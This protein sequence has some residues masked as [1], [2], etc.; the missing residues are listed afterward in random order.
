[1]LTM[2]RIPKQHRVEGHLPC[3]GRKVRENGGYGSRG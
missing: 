1:M 3:I 2:E